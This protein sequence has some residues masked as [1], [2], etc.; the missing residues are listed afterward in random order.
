VF[1]RDTKNLQK[2]PQFCLGIDS[3]ISVDGFLV[4]RDSNSE[5][6]KVHTADLKAEKY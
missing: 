2:V 3:A 6:F 4:V 5:Y 1:D